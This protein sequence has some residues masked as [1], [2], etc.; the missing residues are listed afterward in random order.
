MAVKTAYEALSQKKALVEKLHR[1]NRSQT[2][3]RAV[4]SVQVDLGPERARVETETALSKNGIAT[5]ADLECD[6][7]QK[8]Q[9]QVSKKQS[10]KV[11]LAFS[12]GQ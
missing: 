10:G 4:T 9:P 2:S 5:N 3:S 6:K 7:S 12:F 11:S 8:K 1:K